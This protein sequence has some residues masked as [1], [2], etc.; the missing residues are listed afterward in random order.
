M[1]DSLTQQAQD[2]WM[3]IA[4]EETI[5]Y[6]KVQLDELL[7]LADRLELPLVAVRLSS[8]IDAITEGR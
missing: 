8:A 3:T 2:H 6:L 5:E 7:D 1:I 4:H